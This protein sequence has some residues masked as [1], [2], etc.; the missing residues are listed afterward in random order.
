MS[1]LDAWELKLLEGWEDVFKRGQLTF[2]VL[3]ALR[4]GP[5][6]MAEI[7]QWLT[8]IGD[9]ALTVEERSLYRALQRFH[10]SELVKSTSVSGNRGP[11]RKV[12]ELSPIGERVLVAFIE[13]DIRLFLRP[14]V[15]RLL[16]SHT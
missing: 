12:Y 1:A 8:D 4:D 11:D 13:R 6:H 5:K 15:T 3:L 7:R 10:D 14:E 16:K 2:W 9:G